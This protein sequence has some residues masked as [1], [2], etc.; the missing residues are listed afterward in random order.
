MNALYENDTLLALTHG[1]LHP[2][3][4]AVTERAIASA[5]LTPGARILDVGC[6]TG[7][8]VR[9]LRNLGFDAYGV[10]ASQKLVRLAN[11]PHVTLGDGRMHLGRYD[12]LLL[13]CVLSLLGG[14]SAFLRTAA[15]ALPIGGRLILCEPY[16]IGAVSGMLPVDSCVNGVPD[17]EGYQR[18]LQ[19]AGFDCRTW[20]DETDALRG[21][22]AMLILAFGSADA[23]ICEAAGGCGAL[24]PGMRLGYA[25]SIWERCR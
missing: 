6:G 1:A 18:L 9:L 17:V 14:R 15:Q 23:F 7:N 12:V 10:D 25:T 13:E 8:A 21:F 3:G 19:D 20:C 2:G 16:R 24:P 5:I 4:E 22:V 11:S